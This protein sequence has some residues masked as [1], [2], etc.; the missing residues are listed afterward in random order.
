MAYVTAPFVHQVFLQIPDHARRSRHNLMNFARTLTNPST[1]ASTANTKLEFV[2]LRI[3]PF[4][5]TTSAFLHE[6]RAL[7]P[8]KFRLANIEIPKSDEWARRQREKGIWNRM[9]EVVAEPRYKFFV[10]EGKMFTQ[11]TG[12]PGVWEEVAMRI[13]GQTNRAVKEE[14]AATVGPTGPRGMI[15]RPVVRGPVVLKRPAKVVEEARVRRQT[16]RSSR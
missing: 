15:R 11:K 7:P 2:T 1:A 3:F 14:S 9:L 12:V 4:R 10:K 13:K 6:L 16:A 5:K 8:M